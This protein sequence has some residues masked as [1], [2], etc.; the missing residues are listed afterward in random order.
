MHA[1]INVLFCE[2]VCVC[3][4]CYSCVYVHFVHVCIYFVAFEYACA[5]LCAHTFVLADIEC[6]CMCCF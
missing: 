1:R 2:H 4:L 6:I 3:V 5:L